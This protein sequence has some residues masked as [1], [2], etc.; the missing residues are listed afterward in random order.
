MWRHG[1]FRPVRQHVQKFL[2]SFRHDLQ[3]VFH[4]IHLSLLGQKRVV[5]FLNRM[6]L[7]VELLLKTCK[8]FPCIHGFP[9]GASAVYRTSEVLVQIGMYP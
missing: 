9:P 2:L 1:I 3:R 8:T 7:K 4:G 6:F 5:Q